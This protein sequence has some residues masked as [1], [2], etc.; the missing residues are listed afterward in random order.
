M[1]PG[2]GGSPT[3]DGGSYPDAGCALYGQICTTA[4]DCC[5][6]VPC[7]GGRCEEPNQ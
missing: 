4:A 2:D 3:G 6:G 7:T 1:G 5:N